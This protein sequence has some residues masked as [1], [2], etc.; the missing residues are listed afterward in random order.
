MVLLQV[1]SGYDFCVFW[2]RRY[3]I[4]IVYVH[5]LLVIALACLFKACHLLMVCIHAFVLILLLSES[6]ESM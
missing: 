2:H 3:L 1:Q 6:M 5:F 4:D